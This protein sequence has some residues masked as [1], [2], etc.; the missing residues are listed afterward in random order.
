MI[1]NPGLDAHRGRGS[2]LPDRRADREISDH[3]Q[4]FADSGR[5][6]QL[7]AQRQWISRIPTD[8]ATNLRTLKIYVVDEDGV[9]VGKYLS[10][11]AFTEKSVRPTQQSDTDS[12]SIRYGGMEGIMDAPVSTRSA[13]ANKP[14]EALV[15]ICRR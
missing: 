13:L 14:R 12:F 15:A 11:P 6:L 7:L 9:I 2:L 3:W 1:G 8:P 5:A 4:V 10:P